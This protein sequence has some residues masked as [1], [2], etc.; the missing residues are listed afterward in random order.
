M[1][2]PQ[3]SLGWLCTWAP[4][5]QSCGD[6]SAVP[7]LIWAWYCLQCKAITSRSSSTSTHP[8]SR[9]APRR[10]WRHTWP[11][12][13]LQRHHGG[14]ADTAPH[15]G[16]TKQG[17]AGLSARICPHA[18]HGRPQTQG[19]HL[20]CSH[21]PARQVLCPCTSPT[22]RSMQELHRP[23][24]HTLACLP[25]PGPHQGGEGAYLRSRPES[26]EVSCLS[27]PRWDWG[28]A[29]LC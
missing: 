7:P 29:P 12:S 26:E 3:P 14:P 17:S 2:A 10:F 19:A 11:L 25:W 5:L 18:E 16:H 27:R 28:K 8:P 22:P 6:S 24:P 23:C 21:T 4:C 15:P 1:A 9:P 20:S 13:S